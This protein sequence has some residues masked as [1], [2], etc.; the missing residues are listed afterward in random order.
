MKA[1]KR[2]AKAEVRARELAESQA[3][4]RALKEEKKVFELPF[5]DYSPTH[6]LLT[7]IRPL[8]SPLQRT[9]ALAEL[10]LMLKAEDKKKTKQRR[11]GASR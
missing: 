2:A 9:K 5:S 8:S 6:V 3:K 7:T 11:K 1:L 4:A 10:E